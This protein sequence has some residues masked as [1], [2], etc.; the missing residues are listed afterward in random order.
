MARPTSILDPEKMGQANRL[1]DRPALRPEDL[2]DSSGNPVLG[3]NPRKDLKG[4]GYTISKRGD[5]VNKYGYLANDRALVKALRRKGMAGQV[6]REKEEAGEFARTH[7]ITGPVSRGRHRVLMG[8]E[9]DSAAIRARQLALESERVGR[10][11]KLGLSPSPYTKEAQERLSQ[12][13][14]DVLRDRPLTGI[15]PL[16]TEFHPEPSSQVGN[17]VTNIG[18]PGSG[19]LRPEHL[20]EWQ[21]TPQPKFQSGNLPDPRDFGESGE[22]QHDDPSSVQMATGEEGQTLRPTDI[23]D[24]YAKQKKYWDAFKKESGID[25]D[26]LR[27]RSEGGDAAWTREWED[28]MNK[29]DNFIRKQEG[30]EP[31]P[32]FVHRGVNRIAASHVEEQM[33]DEKLLNELLADNIRFNKEKYWFQRK[34]PETKHGHYVDQ[35][36]NDTGETPESKLRNDLMKQAQARLDASVDNIYQ[37]VTGKR[38]SGRGVNL[39]QQIQSKASGPFGDGGVRDAARTLLNPY[40]IDWDNLKIPIP[41]WEGIVDKFEEV[42]GSRP[43]WLKGR[44]EEEFRRLIG[45]NLGSDGS[46]NIKKVKEQLKQWESEARMQKKV[47]DIRAK[48]VLA[49]AAA[50][51]G[52]EVTGTPAAVDPTGEGVPFSG[53]FVGGKPFT[54]SRPPAAVTRPT[55]QP[56]A[57]EPAPPKGWVESRTVTDVD[58]GQWTQNAFSRIKSEEDARTAAEQGRRPMT[59]EEAKIAHLDAQAAKIRHDIERDVPTKQVELDILKQIQAVREFDAKHGLDL[60]G[61]NR[62]AMLSLMSELSQAIKSLGDPLTMTDEVREAVQEF[63]D[64]HRRITGD[65]GYPVGGS[66]NQVPTGAAAAAQ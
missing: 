21:S 8:V 10:I 40:G 28:A 22:Y 44:K 19:V 17:I 37:V 36:G 27:S 57:K 31:L 34:R 64:I 54:P 4:T 59:L 9:G 6:A 49:E 3:A 53:D 26:K 25:L 61:A 33:K 24:Y 38:V 48:K 43:D 20:D 51:E 12:A 15:S 50:E 66:N 52:G 30:M 16:R 56:A 46:L 62:D 58:S 13:N 11:E 23:P 7:G 1:K 41:T 65:L 29:L 2:V 18:G 35:W 14:K 5:I 42:T 63:L 47:D 32:E 45:G 55:V 39:V 60:T